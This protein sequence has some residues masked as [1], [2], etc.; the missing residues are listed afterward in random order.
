M[1][2]VAAGPPTPSRAARTKGLV[3]L[4]FAVWIVIFTWPA[5][6]EIGHRII[7]GELVGAWRTL[8][9]HDWTLNRLLRDG[10]WPLDAPEIGYP[11]GGPFSSIAPV[12]DLLSLPLQLIFGL[13]PAYNLVVLFHM[14]L[15]CTGGYALA[16]AA[17][18][19]QAGSVTAGTIFGFNSFFLTYGVASAVVETSTVGW[20]AWFL[21]A[22]VR[23]VER[24]TARMALLTGLLFAMAGIASFYWA[25]IVGVLS[26]VVALPALISRLGALDGR[27]RLRLLGLVGLSV[28]VATAVWAP[29]AMALLGTYEAQGALLQDYAERKQ[30]LLDPGIMANLAHDYA[31]LAG[32]LLPGKERLVFHEDMD[33][34]CQSTYAG[35]VAIALASFGLGRGRLRWLVVGLLGAILSL[36]PF[37]F[38]TFT[39]W[40]EEPVWWWLALREAFPPIRMVTSYV[41]FSAFGFLGL[42]VLAGFGVDR[43]HNAIADRFARPLRLAVGVGL[44]AS[45]LVL[46]EVMFVSPVPFP[47]YSA[48]AHIPESSRALAELSGQGAVLDW[49]Q[50]YPE[51][52]VEVSRYFFYQSVHQRPIPYDFAPT[53]YMPGLIESNPFFARLERITYGE[54]YDSGAWNASTLNPIRR[55]VLEMQRMGFDWLVVHPEQVDPARQELLLG[56]LDSLL[57]RER[58]FEDGSAIFR[59][60]LPD[61]ARDAEEVVPL[62]GPTFDEPP[63]E[64][65]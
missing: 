19:R 58:T 49:P 12:N 34:L 38:V 47:I 26:P 14:L 56:Y 61:V 28:V 40:R 10:R 57:E 36:G 64:A 31:T 45:A 8:W 53:S 22:M 50:R 9:A 63:A 27:G 59:V 60:A 42:A 20:V 25:L 35:W 5:V 16:R 46:V 39:S 33:L 65:P 15:A 62:E 51:R 37:V 11:R 1:P 32:F 29:V 13:V 55:G 52:R 43:L 41:R 44:V 48:D 4:W 6:P 3:V 21:A 2:D 54:A 30:E 7:G 24:P 23:L 18:V 17:G